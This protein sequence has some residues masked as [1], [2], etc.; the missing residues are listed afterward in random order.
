[1]NHCGEGMLPDNWAECQTL[2]PHA[3]SILYVN[4][5]SR[6]GIERWAMLM[7]RAADYAAYRGGG[8]ML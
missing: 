8:A 7:Q 2:F 4:T 6:D 5:I 3:K 1:M